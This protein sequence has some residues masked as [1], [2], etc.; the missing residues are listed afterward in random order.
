[1]RKKINL[2]AILA[3]GLIF[4]FLVNMG[5]P[6]PIAKAGEF[7]LPA[8]G[9]MVHLS[10]EFTPAYLKGI[11][12]HPENALKFDFIVYKGDEKLTDAQKR[13]EYTKLAKYF[14]A[15]LA[16]PDDDQW[17]N[18]S[19]YEKDRI[20]KDDF[21]KTEMGRDLLAQDYM[22]KQMTASLIYPRDNLGKKFWEKVYTQA[23]QQFATTNIPVNT[24]NKVW[25]LPDNALIYEKGN[26]AYVLKNHLRVM[27][28]EDYLALQKLSVIA[29]EAKQS[30]QNKSHTIASQ[31]VKEII[32]PALEKEVNTAKNFAPLRQVYSGMLLATWYKR[33]LKESLL[34]KIY[35]NKAK[36]RGVDQDPKNNEQI[37]QQYLKAYKKGVFN[38]IREDVD[39]Y[40]NETIPRKYFSGGGEGY[41][42][43]QKTLD[44]EIVHITSDPASIANEAPKFSNIDVVDVTAK[45]IGAVAPAASPAMTAEAAKTEQVHVMTSPE[46]MYRD[47]NGRLT[48]DDRR[49]RL[50]ASKQY[51]RY[52]FAVVD[53][54]KRIFLSIPESFSGQ[55]VDV[56][57]DQYQVTPGQ[58]LDI[59]DSI[60]YFDAEVHIVTEET[61]VPGGTLRYS[62]ELELTVK[63]ETIPTKELPATVKH[64][65]LLQYNN[66][67][68]AEERKGYYVT[69]LTRREEEHDVYLEK[70]LTLWK[71]LQKQES[72]TERRRKVVVIGKIENTEIRIDSKETLDQLISRLKFKYPKRKDVKLE[73]VDS[74][75]EKW[76]GIDEYFHRM[77]DK[78]QEIQDAWPG[79]DIKVIGAW[80]GVEL[81]L[82][83]AMKTGGTKQVSWSDI[84]AKEPNSIK[85][86]PS[87]SSK[88]IFKVGN[89]SKVVFLSGIHFVD[90]DTFTPEDI[91]KEIRESLNGQTFDSKVSAIAVFINKREY[92]SLSMID[93]MKMAMRQDNVEVG[94][95]LI[96]GK[97]F[98]LN[99][100]DAVDEKLIE[101]KKLHKDARG[102]AEPLVLMAGSEKNP[103]IKTKYN[104]VRIREEL[105][106]L[107][108]YANRFSEDLWK[109]GE[110]K[111]L[112]KSGVI[113]SRFDLKEIK[114]KLEGQN[115]IFV[116]AG[117][118]GK[119]VP[120]TGR[121]D[122]L[123]DDFQLYWKW[124]AVNIAKG[125]SPE[126]RTPE[127]LERIAIQETKADFDA[128]MD[129]GGFVE[130]GKTPLGGIDLN[131]ANLNLQIKR[132]GK[133]VPLPVSQQDL[134]KIHIDGLVPEI[135]EIKSA[136]DS[137]LMSEL[138]YN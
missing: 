44:K 23:Q 69:V 118:N 24:F 62:N 85:D 93:D 94:I 137:T 29:S 2:R 74:S 17:V 103:Y 108:V 73:V 67:K 56:N 83:A 28:E 131:S 7:H 3:L 11:V 52:S 59:T 79:S 32:L 64:D 100:T 12:I 120:I 20:I 33:A 117:P 92:P 116:V 104:R 80:N 72:K 36:V 77:M 58:E 53:A 41:D 134:E 99:L 95:G 122:A 42:L 43:A 110:F 10:P 39:R 82:D 13:E 89:K 38:F 109:H 127:I 105:G 14:M 107:Y 87:G 37:Y 121:E 75:E 15:S 78:W 124:R 119:Y 86:M 22:L 25:I 45:E 98:K 65:M 136:A 31:I 50:A 19:P 84:V 47:D 55:W 16:I 51:F 27:L 138:F 54:A 49:I 101:L 5:G 35:A 46:W 6:L 123:V 26:T 40:T 66:N 88:V 70:M 48:I 96:Q 129:A 57:G 18:L 9:M 111:Y 21:G 112:F 30:L 125:L 97:G 61:L 106:K 114:K 8:P 133:G 63:F 132:D 91:L 126:Q 81:T 90:K 71:Q 76:V 68:E 113:K 135:I 115:V 102:G 4:V 130:A 128:A 34:N 60:N 1:M